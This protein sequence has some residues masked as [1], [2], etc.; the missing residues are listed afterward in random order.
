VMDASVGGSST[1]GSSTGGALGAAGSAGT[2]VGAGGVPS[3][4]NVEGDAPS[5]CS[6]TVDSGQ[7]CGRC[8]HDCCGGACVSGKCQPH[9]IYEGPDGA[10][11]PLEEIAVYGPYV[12]FSST[13]LD[14]VMRIPVNGGERRTIW[15][16]RSY[17]RSIAT[18]ASGV[19]VAGVSSPL[20]AG[21]SG[22]IERVSPDGQP[23]F[24][25]DMNEDAS[26]IVLDENHA[27]WLSGNSA[28]KRWSKSGGPTS[29]VGGTADLLGYFLAA[30]SGS[31]FF[32]KIAGSQIVQRDGAGIAPDREL[33]ADEVE[34]SSLAVNAAYVFWPLGSPNKIR[35][36]A[37]NGVNPIDLVANAGTPTYMVAD[38]SYVYWLSW[39]QSALRA[40]RA[41]TPGVATDLA[42][43]LPNPRKLAH[44]AG[45]L[46]VTYGGGRGKIVRVAKP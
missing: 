25:L 22:L 17:V 42:T 39:G 41:D 16:K 46:Y 4:A 40:A 1:A 23:Q 12:Y 28:I 20:D 35:R 31:V 18:D 33:A 29:A 24:T 8:D 2:G 19:Y 14:G 6:A 9:V 43:D 32:E 34:V 26:N 21:T 7:N 38:D 27:Y 45:C 10:F 44:D 37:V 30:R 11:E 15:T 3:D 36:V 13:R 5:E